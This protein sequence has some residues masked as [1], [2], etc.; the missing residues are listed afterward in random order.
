MF[1][2]CVEAPM[3][4]PPL[5]VTYRSAVPLPALPGLIEMTGAEEIP[6]PITMLRGGVDAPVAKPPAPVKA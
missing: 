5:V 2:R 1:T 4:P 6:V 3:R